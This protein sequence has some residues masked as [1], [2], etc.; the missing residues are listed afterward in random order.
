MDQLQTIVYGIIIIIII[1]TVI[2]VV[3]NHSMQQTSFVVGK[4]IGKRIASRSC[5]PYHLI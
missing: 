3:I 1:I 2:V 4:G 5:V